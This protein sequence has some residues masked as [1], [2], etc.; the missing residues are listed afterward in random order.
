MKANT[1]SILILLIVPVLFVLVIVGYELNARAAE[2]RYTDAYH[3]GYTAGELFAVQKIFDC[4]DADIIYYN[5]ID[6][7][8]SDPNV[9][10]I[11]YSFE[12]EP[13]E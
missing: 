5:D 2:A 1:K 11:R 12:K 10:V 7:S 9:D 6:I 3:Q 4:N 8:Y 13:T